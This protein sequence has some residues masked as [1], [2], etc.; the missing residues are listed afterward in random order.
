MA[1]GRLRRLR[2]IYVLLGAGNRTYRT[3]YCLL[4]I[5]DPECIPVKLFI[6]LYCMTVFKAY[7]FN[8]R[9]LRNCFDGA[10]GIYLGMNPNKP[11]VAGSISGE[12][13]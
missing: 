10:T 12:D 7:C 6:V 3:R 11:R 5:L 8:I 9:R 13:R 2:C 1:V 4:V